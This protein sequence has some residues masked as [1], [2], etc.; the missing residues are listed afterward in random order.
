MI[1]WSNAYR[2]CLWQIEFTEAQQLPAYEYRRT[3]RRYNS[4]N[5]ESELNKVEFSEVQKVWSKLKWNYCKFQLISGH[6]RVFWGQA[7]SIMKNTSAPLTAWLPLIKGALHWFY[8]W[9]SV[10]S[11]WRELLSLWRHFHNVFC[12]SRGAEKTRTMSLGLSQ[13]W[14]VDSNLGIVG[15]IG[16]RVFEAWPSSG[17]STLSMLFLIGFF[18]VPETPCSVQVQC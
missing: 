8:T 17:A 5:A 18:Q 3:W 9:W 10:F 6:F 14:L 13:L 12:G 11:L 16:S 4:K 15:S 7:T 1:R 2:K